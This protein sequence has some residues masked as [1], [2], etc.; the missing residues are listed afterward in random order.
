MP[1]VGKN[2]RRRV[3]INISPILKRGKGSPIAAQLSGGIKDSAAN[4]ILQDNYCI[5]QK[6]RVR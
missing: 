2:N 6:T 1:Y 4:D 3:G 5:L